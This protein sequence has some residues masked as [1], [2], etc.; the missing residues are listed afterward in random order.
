MGLFD[1]VGKKI[2][3]G[4]SERAGKVSEDKVADGVIPNSELPSREASTARTFS[5]EE[6]E[7]ELALAKRRDLDVSESARGLLDLVSGQAGELKRLVAKM[8]AASVGKD[9]EYGVIGETMRKQ[10][11]SRM[12]VLFESLKAPET[13]YRSLLAYRAGLLRFLGSADRILRDNRY[14]LHF[15]EAEMKEFATS[16]R[17]L[18]AT[19]NEL[20]KALNGKAGK[21]EEYAFLESRL[22]EA[23][24]GAVVQAGLEKRVE[25]CIA[26][27][28]K[29]GG[30]KEEN[31]A[32]L[33]LEIGR[34]KKEEVRL[35][36][37]QSGLRSR[38]ADALGPL[39]KLLLKYAHGAPKKE[40]AIAERY[41]ADP[42][43]A[44][45]ESGDSQECRTLLAALRQFAEKNPDTKYP[46]SLS[47]FESGIAGLLEEHSR[48]DGQLNAAAEDVRALE[49][50]KAKEQARAAER[51]QLSE[52]L[53]Q[54]KTR[55]VEEQSK[56]GKLLDEI[57]KK[58]SGLLHRQLKISSLEG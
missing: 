50:R 41:A 20:G 21:A 12:T 54:R 39:H 11:V 15:F 9:V 5:I 2:K 31:A 53:G 24:A 32:G 33:E 19:V 13:D 42:V 4:N 6:L 28:N 52:E 29:L 17:A 1:W 55:L 35:S 57:S 27:L 18:D 47:S 40:K 7:L 3:R 56:Q 48:L 23:K 16:M 49:A 14:L 45:F 44:L 25:E 26:S 22:K 36:G 58:A 8:D 43:K 34:A 10:F 51:K 38:V 30:E 46:Q 37:L